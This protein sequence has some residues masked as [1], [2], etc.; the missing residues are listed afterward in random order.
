MIAPRLPTW[1]FTNWYGEEWEFTTEKRVEKQEYHS[2][3]GD[4]TSYLNASDRLHKSQ[5]SASWQPP[6]PVVAKGKKPA[7]NDKKNA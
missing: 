3:F 1:R 6:G 7:K 5:A 2:H 4:G